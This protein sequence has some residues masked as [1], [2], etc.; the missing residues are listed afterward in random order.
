MA[1]IR[2]YRSMLDLV[3]QSK[4]IEEK[5]LQQQL[6]LKEKEREK[7]RLEELQTALDPGSMT[8]TQDD[9]EM[10]SHVSALENEFQSQSSSQTSLVAK[11][12]QVMSTFK[13]KLKIL[14]K[15]IILC[16]SLFLFFS[17]F[18]SISLPLSCT[19]DI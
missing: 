17:L 9:H 3:L 12:V 2:L 18:F 6:E 15:R 1:Q 7:K 11:Q 4:E 8:L 19:S 5:H 10:M 16:L 14:F 13:G